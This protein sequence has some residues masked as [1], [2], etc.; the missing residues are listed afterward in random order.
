MKSAILPQV[1]VEPQLRADVESVLAKGESL[2]EFVEEAV[3]RAVEYRR[4][5]DD[6]HARGEASW[7][8][9][10]RT[11][12]AYPAE[13]VLEELRALTDARRKQLGL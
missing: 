2:S 6:F 12:E 8:E 11:G 4:V 3:R 10:Q 7:Q 13:E 1:R 5:Q 9:Y